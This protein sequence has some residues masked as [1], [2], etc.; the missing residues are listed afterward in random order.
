M[1][2]ARFWGE[3]LS[4]PRGSSGEGFWPIPTT[5]LRFGFGVMFCSPGMLG[6]LVLRGFP[7]IH[8]S[9]ATSDSRHLAGSY[10]S[11]RIG[12]LWQSIRSGAFAVSRAGWVRVLGES[13]GGAMVTFPR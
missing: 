5:A 11:F 9:G 7:G 2:A 13:C 12:F 4:I 6:V 1:S 3:R 8:S 10:I